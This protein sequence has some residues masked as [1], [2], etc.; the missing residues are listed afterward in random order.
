MRAKLKREGSLRI[1]IPFDEAMKL[2][3]K[4][5]PPPEGWAA[6]EKSLKKKPPSK[7][8]KHKRAA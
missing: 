2:T 7:A 5:K 6:Y 8:K 4:V 1:P 3:V